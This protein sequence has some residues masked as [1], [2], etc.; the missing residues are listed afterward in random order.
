MFLLWISKILP[1]FGTCSCQIYWWFSTE[2]SQGMESERT[3]YLFV[4][5]PKSQH[6][7]I[8]KNS[9]NLVFSTHPLKKSLV[10][11]IKKVLACDTSKFVKHV[12]NSL[13]SL[14]PVSYTETIM[15]AHTKTL[16]GNI[17]LYERNNK[18]QLVWKEWWCRLWRLLW[19]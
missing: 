16:V 1:R 2:T 19:K 3:I 13:F 17:Y 4:M 8:T 18:H 14:E 10:F 11:T 7:V 9:I 5:F 6:L 12:K 15:L